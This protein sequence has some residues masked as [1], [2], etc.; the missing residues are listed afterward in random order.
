[1]FKVPSSHLCWILNISNSKRK[2][3]LFCSESFRA[4]EQN[5]LVHKTQ[6]WMFIELM[7]KWIQMTFSL[8]SSHFSAS[9]IN[10]EMTILCKSTTTKLPTQRVSQALVK[11]LLVWGKHRRASTLLPPW[12]TWS[13]ALQGPDCSSWPWSLFPPEEDHSKE[14]QSQV[15]ASFC[16]QRVFQ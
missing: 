4:L 8:F 3:V 9:P 2:S 1:M 12:P 13:L 10:P 14:P 15:E 7:K 6:K 11:P 5:D 16:F